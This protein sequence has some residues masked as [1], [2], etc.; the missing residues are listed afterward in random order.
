MIFFRNMKIRTKLFTG[1][2]IMI[3]FMGIIGLTGYFR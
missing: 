1:F 3:L 2:S